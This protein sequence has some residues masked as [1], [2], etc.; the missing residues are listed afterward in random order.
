MKIYK[1]S[2]DITKS[3]II[4]IP[5]LVRIISVVVQYDQLA[6]YAIVGNN[7]TPRTEVEVTILGTGCEFK[8]IPK[9]WIFRGTHLMHTGL[10]EWHVWTKYL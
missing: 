1:H 7:E 2:L 6:L 9:G 4:K 8:P 10:L 5:N 3:Q